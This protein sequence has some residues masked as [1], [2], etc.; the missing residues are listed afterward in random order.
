MNNNDFNANNEKK[1]ENIAEDSGVYGMSYSPSDGGYTYS[2]YRGYYQPTPEEKK[3]IKK[4]RRLAAVIAIT[5]V[6]AFALCAVAGVAG[7]FIAGYVRGGMS[8]DGTGAPSD[9]GESTSDSGQNALL[10]SV[11]NAVVYKDPTDTDYSTE[12][13]DIIASVKPSVVEIVTE[14]VVHNSWY[15]NYTQS[16]AGSGV[17]I[18]KEENSDTEYYVVTNNHVIEGSDNITVRLTD[19]SE[20]KATLVGTD[21]FSDIALVKIS[22]EEGKTLPLAVISDSSKLLDGQEIFVVGN[23]LGTLGG[24]VSK[25]IISCTERRISVDGINMTLLQIDAA[26][27]PGNSG[28]ALFDTKG[29]LVGVVNAKYSDEEVEG[30]GF[31]VPVNKAMETVDSLYRYGYVKGIASLDLDLS[32]QSY[33]VGG[34]AVVRPTQSGESTVSGRAKDK[35]GAES[36]FTLSNGDFINAVDGKEV[37]SVNSF[38]SLLSE[39]KVGDSVELTVYRAET[40]GGFWGRYEYVEY[41]VTVTLTEYVPEYIKN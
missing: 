27:N 17:I 21:I 15:G 7:A 10:P 34:S 39:Y 26:V 20:Y 13:T 33:T 24:S 28:G 38:L 31:A 9:S 3:K 16:G 19:G 41:T 30:L 12:L 6:S 5:L 23:P 37:S 32:D 36:D 11:G 4:K 35:N 1:D 25:G 22:V 14:Y 40:S 18:M 29:N 8:A 2:P